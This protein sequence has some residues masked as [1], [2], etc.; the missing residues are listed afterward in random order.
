MGSRSQTVTPICGVNM[1]N[2]PA[3]LLMVCFGRR[4][5]FIGGVLIA[6]FAAFLQGDAIMIDNFVLFCVLSMVLGI[7]HGYA[8]FYRYA[9]TDCATEQAR[10]KAIFYVLAGGLMAAFFGAEIARNMVRWVPDYLYAGCYFSASAMQLILL[11]ALAGVE[12]V[13]YWWQCAGC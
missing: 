10:P 6:A 4:P 12:F 9:A 7:T 8:S 11:L 5:I 13:L 2:L 1:T 3:S